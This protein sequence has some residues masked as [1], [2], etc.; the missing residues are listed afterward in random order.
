MPSEKVSLPRDPEIAEGQPIVE[1]PGSSGSLRHPQADPGRRVILP[2]LTSP[3]PAFDT[4]AAV[5]SRSPLST[6]PAG[7]MSRRFRNVGPRDTGD[8]RPNPHQHVRLRAA[9]LLGKLGTISS[10]VDCYD[11]RVRA[12][13]L[14]GILEPPGVYPMTPA[15][16][17]A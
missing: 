6:M 16:P 5:C 9:N 15:A 1:L 8:T 10:R 17:S 2:V 3:N 7:I 13:P 14:M 4:S 12:E 11:F